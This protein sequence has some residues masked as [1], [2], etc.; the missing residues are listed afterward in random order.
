MAK[1][2]FSNSLDSSIN[3]YTLL[4]KTSHP[5]MLEGVKGDR[6]EDEEAA[7]LLLVSDG[8]ALSGPHRC[9]LPIASAL[10]TLMGSTLIGTPIRVLLLKL[11]IQKLCPL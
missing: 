11:P 6:E 4:T 3:P 5:A 2:L 9:L 8:S 10:C 1:L 7:C